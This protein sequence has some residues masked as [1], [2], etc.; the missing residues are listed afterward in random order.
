LKIYKKGIN[1]SDLPTSERVAQLKAAK[2][3]LEYSLDK[4]AW[5]PLTDTFPEI[6]IEEKNEFEKLKE[7]TFS[8][9][10]DF[11]VEKKSCDW[12]KNTRRNYRSVVKYLKIGAGALDIKNEKITTLQRM[13]YRILLA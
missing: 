10:I 12:S 13:H 3:A 8:E 2:K 4:L 5:N 7:M 9:A 6:I 1:S 11:A